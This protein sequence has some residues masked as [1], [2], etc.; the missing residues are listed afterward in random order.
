VLLL[1]LACGRP[2]EDNRPSE[3]DHKHLA[4]RELAG[5]V[6]LQDHTLAL[7]VDL[8]LLGTNL[9]VIDAG[10]DSLFHIFDIRAKYAHRQFGR[11]G[12]GPGEFTSPWT[13]DPSIDS[14]DEMWV[15]D[16]GQN[17]LTL[18]DLGNAG[19][20]I[21]SPQVKRIVNIHSEGLPTG[22]VHVDSDKILSAGFFSSGRLGEFDD[23]GLLRSYH[24]QVPSVDGTVPPSVIQHAYQSTLVARPSR[25]RVALV[26]RHASRI[27][28]FTADGCRLTTAEGPLHVA[29][30]YRLA[31][32][33]DQPVFSSGS[34]LRFGYVD[35]TAS[36]EHIFA[37][38]SGRTRKGYPGEANT[39]RHVHVFDWEGHFL[40]AIRL[41]EAVI[42]ITVDDSGTIMFGVRHHPEPAIVRFD[43]LGLVPNADSMQSSD[44]L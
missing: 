28:I 3:L 17:R 42:S 2:P 37:L 1:A 8:S 38:F 30:V 7:P 12:A 26:T 16:I 44:R 15:Y 39:G 25:D 6:L 32:R 14:A 24:G 22:P 41:D 29:P 43:L 36:T 4:P 23:G 13:L 40:Y 9:V 33:G 11:R 20:T 35:A 21:W 34:D 18:L 5:E 10:V 31:D 27:E 19:D